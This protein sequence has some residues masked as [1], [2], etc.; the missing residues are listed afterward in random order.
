MVAQCDASFWGPG[1]SSAHSL[2]SAHQFD[3][4]RPS[5][6]PSAEEV[7]VLAV[8]LQKMNWSA[9]ANQKQRRERSRWR[10]RLLRSTSQ[11]HPIPSLQ[12]LHVGWPWLATAMHQ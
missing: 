5:S 3:E 1:P 9:L 6:L 4:V 11:Q 2:D 10:L 8:L 7:A 12:G